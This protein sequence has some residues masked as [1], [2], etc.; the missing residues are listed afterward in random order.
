MQNKKKKYFKSLSQ[1][2]KSYGLIRELSYMLSENKKWWL[3]PIL[4]VL[5]LFGLLI[6]VGGSTYAPFIYSIF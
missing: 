3:I 6:I 1:K 2:N 5:I 4:F